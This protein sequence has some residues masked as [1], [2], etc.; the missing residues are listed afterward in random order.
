MKEKTAARPGLQFQM[1]EFDKLIEPLGYRT[2]WQKAAFL[3][4]APS[5]LSKLRNGHQLASG[6]FVA[7][8]RAALPAIPFECLFK[9]VRSQPRQRR[10]AP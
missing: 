10:T 4:V 9:V 6:E 5:V 3:R 7:A 2:D 8:V 1:E